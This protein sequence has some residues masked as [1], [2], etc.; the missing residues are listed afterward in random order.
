MVNTGLHSVEL[1]NPP[2]RCKTPIRELEMNTQLRLVS[3][4]SGF[5]WGMIPVIYTN[6]NVGGIV[7]NRAWLM[8]GVVG[9]LVGLM[10]GVCA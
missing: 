8:A 5:I 4:L 7:R 6:W 2:Q 9:A 1:P 3:I 10:T